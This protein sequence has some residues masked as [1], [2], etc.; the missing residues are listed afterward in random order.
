MA[1]EV[2]NSRSPTYSS[3]LE[4]GNLPIELWDDI[5]RRLPGKEL[6][7][8]MGVDPRTCVYISTDRVL[9][10]TAIAVALEPA[11]EI[12]QGIEDSRHRSQALLDIAKIEAQHDVAA[13]KVTTQG[14]EDR[15]H[16]SQALR[17]IV[18]IEA[19]HNLEAAKV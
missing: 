11:K 12:A 4:V 8:L 7:K 10:A 14:I 19:Q 2:I 9:R 6:L 18:K 13:A 17:E 5:F 3:L 15:F 1:H 16:Q